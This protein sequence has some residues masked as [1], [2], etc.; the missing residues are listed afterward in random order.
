[1]SIYL[2]DL[3]EQAR[4]EVERD[5]RKNRPDLAKVLDDNE[6]GANEYSVDI[7]VGEYLPTSEYFTV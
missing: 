4:G 5:I 6:S 2:R 1:M 7:E 3:N